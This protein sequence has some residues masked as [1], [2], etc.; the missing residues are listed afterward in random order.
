MMPDVK[1]FPVTKSKKTNVPSKTPAY[2]NELKFN[3]NI[4]TQKFIYN[5]DKQR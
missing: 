5:D 2:I 3:I 4:D 1:V